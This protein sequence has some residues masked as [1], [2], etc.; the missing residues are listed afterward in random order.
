MLANSWVAP[1]EATTLDPVEMPSILVEAS[2]VLFPSPA[3]FGA[4]E[5]LVPRV[6]PVRHGDVHP[7]ISTQR[8]FCVRSPDR[9]GGG[10]EEK[11]QWEIESRG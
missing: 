10:Q 8:A 7:W 3:T 9:G 6:D 11:A 1:H 4:S 5:P 2:V